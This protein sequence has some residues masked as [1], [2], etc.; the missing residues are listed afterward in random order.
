MKQCSLNET[1]KLIKRW[2]RGNHETLSASITYH[3]NKHGDG[4]IAI[5]LKELIRFYHDI[6]KERQHLYD[7]EY[8]LEGNVFSG[9]YPNILTYVAL[10]NDLRVQIIEYLKKLK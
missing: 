2:D 10:V 7:T 8:K 9:K 4:D 5:N 1:K 3:T 6:K